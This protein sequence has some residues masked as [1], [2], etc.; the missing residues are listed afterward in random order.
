MVNIPLPS[1]H[2]K[3]RFCIVSEKTKCG[4]LSSVIHNG[5]SAQVKFVAII[6]ILLS[7]SIIELNNDGSKISILPINGF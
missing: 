4:K 6:S 3:I 1:S 7:G 5:P 2:L